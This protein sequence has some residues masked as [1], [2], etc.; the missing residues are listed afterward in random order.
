M[1]L[2]TVKKRDTQIE[3]LQQ[4]L[5]TSSCDYT[6]VLLER[7]NEELVET[8]HKLSARTYTLRMY[9]LGKKDL[10]ELVEHNEYLADLVKK[11]ENVAAAL[12]SRQQS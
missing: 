4:Q 3:K 9:E 1:A 6:N 7:T 12:A 11:W 5:E 10:K 2:A 8:S